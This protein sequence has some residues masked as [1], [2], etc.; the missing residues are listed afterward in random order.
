VLPFL[1]RGFE[2][3]LPENRPG[4]VEEDVEMAPSLFHGVSERT[5]VVRRGD[6]AAPER[7]VEPGAAELRFQ[8]FSGR[9]VDVGTEDRGSLLAESLQATEPIPPAAPVTIAVFPRDDRGRSRLFDEAG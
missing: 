7:E 8:S 4:V 9:P 1:V 5:H 6:V 2:E 3:R